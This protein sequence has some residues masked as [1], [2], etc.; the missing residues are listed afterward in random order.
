MNYLKHFFSILLV[1]TLISCSEDSPTGNDMTITADNYFAGKFN[2]NN[3]LIQEI[4]QDYIGLIYNAS[5]GSDPDDTDS[6][7]VTETTYF[8]K[9]DPITR[10]RKKLFGFTI[11]KRLISGFWDEDLIEMFQQKNWG[12]GNEDKYVEGV[13]VYYYDG[14]DKLWST[15]LGSGEQVGSTFTIEEATERENRNVYYPGLIEIK[16]SFQC[17]VYDEDGNSADLEGTSN[18]HIC[19]L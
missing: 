15:V 19:I 7:F 10:D 5:S 12:Y 1:I 18:T 9:A 3:V 13:E 16:V 14:N 17:K 8:S 11:M 2:G 4:S 6:T